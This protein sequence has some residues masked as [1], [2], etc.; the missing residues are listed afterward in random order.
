MP[1]VPVLSCHCTKSGHVLIIQGQGMVNDTNQ[2]VP[3]ICGSVAAT[4]K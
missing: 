4:G 3:C 1:T 2:T